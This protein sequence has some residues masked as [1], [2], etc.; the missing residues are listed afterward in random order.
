MT[1]IFKG[2]IR[3]LFLE[4]IM[5]FELLF[6]LPTLKVLCYCIGRFK[7]KS[8]DIGLGPEPLINN[9]YHKMALEKQGYSV[10]T[11]VN[12]VYHITTD[13]DYRGD[14]LRINKTRI[15]RYFGKYYF[16]LRAVARYRCIYMY[17]NGGPL[18]ADSSLRKYEPILLKLSKTKVVVMPY[19]GDVNIMSNFPNLVFK[20]AID[21]D[22]PE[23]YKN[24]PLIE[25][26]VRRWTTHADHVIS[27]CDWVD[28]TYHWDT[29][30]LAHFSIDINKFAP[31]RRDLNFYDCEFTAE[32]P[33]RILH[34]P[35]HRT[36]KGTDFFIRAVEELKTEGYS[37]ELVLVQG[38]SNDEV[39]EAMSIV[40]VVADQLLVGWYAMFA[41][42][43]MSMGK[44]V[45]CYLRQDLIELYLSSGNLESLEEIPHINS[46][47]LEVKLNIL[48]ILSG[49]ISL[50][51]RSLKGI[52]F[53][54]KYHSLEY[55]GEMFHKINLGLEIAPSNKSVNLE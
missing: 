31:F 29:L 50:R 54:N 18:Y 10:E 3:G 43:A 22:Y 17:F 27:G 14:K 12:Q 35:N 20:H 11:F 42:E 25:A 51:E 19:G 40:D 44:P 48:K 6:G 2:L 46:H 8:I 13:F 52:E 33:L 55:I 4:L 21:A 49:E 26:Q 45:I 15:G 36:I 32:R 7:K 34:A 1:L 16:F 30:T 39:L 38:K 37:I 5:L 47:F 28:F 9:I 24:L 53:V 23:F 41:L